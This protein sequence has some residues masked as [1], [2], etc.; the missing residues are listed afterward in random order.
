LNSDIRLSITFRDHPKIVKLHK[1]LDD[2]GIASL[3]ILWA[4]T[5]AHRHKGGLYG[6]DV[7]DVEI[8]ARWSGENGALVKTLHDLRLL[9]CAAC[10][11]RES[12][13]PH[14]IVLPVGIH[15][16]RDW[17]GWAFFSDERSA[18]ASKAAEARWR[19]QAKKDALCGSHKKKMR[20]A[21]KTNAGSNATST[22][23]DAPSPAPSP[24]PPPK[25]VEQGEEQE[26]EQT[27]ALRGG[28][29]GAPPAAALPEEQGGGNGAGKASTPRLSPRDSMIEHLRSEISKG[30]L[31]PREARTASLFRKKLKITPTEAQELFP[32]EQGAAT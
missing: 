22:K 24:A 21:S 1:L 29:F 30:R 23:I 26:Q 14:D 28:A 13:E 12:W 8:A 9:D 11:P 10:P 27:A 32:D 16:W 25:K 18:R 3:V 31:T 15:D 5:A 2:S 6:M 20:N 17:Q 7:L 19:E 4:Y